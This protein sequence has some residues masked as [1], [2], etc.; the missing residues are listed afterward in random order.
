MPLQG[1]EQKIWKSLSAASVINGVSPLGLASV[2]TF[3]PQTNSQ[4]NRRVLLG[5]WIPLGC[6]AEVFNCVKTLPGPVHTNGG[7]GEVSSGASWRKAQILEPL[8]HGL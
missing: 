8:C 1:P 4:E 5:L 2:E 3:R 6:L 7:P